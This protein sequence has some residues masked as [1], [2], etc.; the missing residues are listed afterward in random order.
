MDQEKIG[1]FIKE[2]RT[3]NNMTQKDLADKYNVTYQ[4]VSKWENGKNL[5]DVYLL[6]QMSKDF[7]IDVE[8]LLDGVKKKKTKK[9]LPIILLIIFF[10]IIISFIILNNNKTFNSKTL[11]SLCS[12]FNVTGFISYDSKKSSIYIS[13]IDYQGCDDDEIYYKINSELLE[14]DNLIASNSITTESSLKDYLKDLKFYIDSYEQVCKKYDNDSLHLK[15]YAY[16]KKNMVFDIPLK[17]DNS[18]K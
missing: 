6:R 9:L 4:A 8:D 11:S 7:N 3:K 16:G 12:D 14:S 10:I 15:I 13:N 17:L 5:P 1:K 18:C 2:I